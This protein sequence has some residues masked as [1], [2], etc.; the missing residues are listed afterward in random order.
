MLIIFGRPPTNFGGRKTIRL[1]VLNADNPTLSVIFKV[2][3]C[4]PT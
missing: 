2:I 4:F 1:K 3:M